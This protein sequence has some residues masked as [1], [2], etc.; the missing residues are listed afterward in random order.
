MYLL[1]CYRILLGIYPNEFRRQFADEMLHVFEQRARE[2][3]AMGK[4]ASL[5]FIVREFFSIVKGAQMM[6]IEKIEK[7]NKTQTAANIQEADL[8]VSEIQKLRDAAVSKMVHAIAT[9][10]FPGA[11][12]YSEE[13]AR[14]QA[15]IR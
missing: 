3:F 15:L 13:E 11:R 5:V 7:K 2:R 4:T 9:H 1:A 10:D 8:T 6:W 12:R 14:L